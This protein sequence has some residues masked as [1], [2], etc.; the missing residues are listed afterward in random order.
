LLCACVAHS[1]SVLI[2]NKADIV[3]P[4]EYESCRA[5][6]EAFNQRTQPIRSEYGA[7]DVSSLID[8][9][10][11]GAGSLPN[12]HEVLSSRR[13]L[14][15]LTSA[16]AVE[17][18]P[19]ATFSTF[20]YER[21][22]PFHPLKLRWF[23][24]HKYHTLQILR[25]KGFCWMATRNDFQG[26]WSGAGAALTVDSM[27]RWYS[28]LSEQEWVRAGLS[29]SARTACE[30]KCLG[31]HGD[32]RQEL[33]FIGMDAL[34]EAAIVKELDACLVDEDQMDGG[35]ERWASFDDPWSDWSITT[36]ESKMESSTR[37]A[38]AEREKFK[39]S[40]WME[41]E[42]HQAGQTVS[43]DAPTEIRKAF[44][45]FRQI[46][47]TQAE[48]GELEKALVAWCAFLDSRR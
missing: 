24:M 13:W 29:A 15:N 37:D 19:E 12:P 17:A 44:E 39:V 31:D 8:A 30:A 21:R 3:T 18:T 34:D 20:V 27:C 45:E 11:A 7:V 4:T 28:S 1:A 10:Q 41:R 33:V 26:E 6:I 23:V 16:G 32:R 2:L 38:V 25:S 46:G 36:V 43:A 9:P 5:V 22:R 14:Q 35:A 47:E 48:A 40:L 42:Q